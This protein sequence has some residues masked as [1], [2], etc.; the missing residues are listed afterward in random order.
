MG[1]HSKV[2]FDR[3]KQDPARKMLQKL[4]LGIAVIGIIEELLLLLLCKNRLAATLGLLLGLWTAAV[5]S[6]Y[7]YRSLGRALELDEKIR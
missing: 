1:L 4:L 6:V 7:I 3:E 5:N 2:L